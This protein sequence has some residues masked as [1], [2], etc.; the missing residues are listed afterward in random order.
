MTEQYPAAA[1]PSAP[2]AGKT[3]LVVGLL[4][5]FL[6]GFGV[7]N[8]YLGFT[9]KAVIQI[10]VTFVTFGFGAIWGVIEG[11]LYLA[12][13]DPKWSVDADGVPLV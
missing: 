1:A 9:K 4:G 11:I 3:R 6:G 5:I 8:F 13:K 10:I 12:S 2:V 7:H